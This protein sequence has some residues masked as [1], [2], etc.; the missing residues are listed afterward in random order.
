MSDKETRNEENEEQKMQ[1][2]TPQAKESDEKNADLEDA[3]V[4][5]ADSEKLAETPVTSEDDEPQANDMHKEMDDAIAEDSEDEDSGKRHDIEMKDYHPMSMQELIDELNSLVKNEKIQAIKDHVEEIKT[6]FNAKFEE[7]MEQ[8]KEDFLEEGGNIIDFH[9]ST[10]VKKEF[11]SAYFDY[12]EKRNQHYQELKQN[13]NENLKRRLA[14]IEELKGM[15]GAG[16]DMN[17]NFKEFKELQDRWKK[18]GPIPRDQYNTVWNNYHHHVEHF[19]DFLH[20]DREFRDMDFKHNL[21]QKLKMI[22]RAEELAQETNINRA[23]RELQM[24]HKMWKEDVGPV[25]KQYREDIWEVSAR[26]QQIKKEIDDLSAWWN[27]RKLA[28]QDLEEE[29][30]QQEDTEMLLRLIQIRTYLWS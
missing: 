3:M 29:E 17:A 10:P 27:Q 9:Y 8:K 7:E 20:L 1:A 11:N 18:A 6:E 14:I 16:A 2:S 5:E 23:F 22:A 26:Q 30:Q 24:L 15:V 21:E 4:E 13:L 19:Y 28:H 25:E 12:K